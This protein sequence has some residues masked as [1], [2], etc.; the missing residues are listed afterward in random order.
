MNNM[1]RIAIN[2]VFRVTKE[3]QAILWMLIMP[4]V[5]VYLFGSIMVDQS[6]QTVWLPVFNHDEHELAS[7]FVEQLK[8]EKFYVDIRSAT[9]EKWVKNW[10][11]AV[12]LPATFSEDILQGKKVDIEF[13][14]GKGNF[15]HTLTAQ[16]HVF[17][18]IVKFTGALAFVDVVQNKWTAN[19]K[20]RFEEELHKSNTLQIEEKKAFSLRPPPS[21][22]G[23]TLPAYLIMFMLMNTVMFGGITIVNDRNNYQMM[24]L[25]STPTTQFELLAGKLLGYIFVPMIQASILLAAGNLL[26]GVPLGDH[27]WVLAPF[28]LCFAVCCGSLGVLFGTL[29]SSVQQVAGL[30]NLTVMLLSAIG[31]CW[32]PIEVAPDFM[33][34]IAFFTP[35]YWGVRGLNDVM[36]FGKSID[37]VLW[38]CFILLLFAALFSG[39]AIPI[40]RKK[41]F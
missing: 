30:G 26:F 20:K 34:S 35:A 15:E 11:R 36:A 14:Q 41:V 40:L 7:L 27:P 21:R 28:L 1:L 10:S 22:F 17:N 32:W 39:I 2:D 5:F 8:D 12:I 25:A 33:K 19:T 24:R 4:L 29:C 9:E 16:T 6:N 37:G 3:K 31:G 18:K 23:F 38:E 13:M